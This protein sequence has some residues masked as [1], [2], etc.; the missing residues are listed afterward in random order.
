LAKVRHAETQYD[1]LLQLGIE[2]S[3][4]CEEVRYEVDDVF[5]K[6]EYGKT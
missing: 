4:A 5:E 3:E 1:D 2:K 6:R